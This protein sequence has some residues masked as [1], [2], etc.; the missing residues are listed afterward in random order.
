MQLLPPLLCLVTQDLPHSL[1]QWALWSVDRTME[2]EPRGPL[3]P[4][5]SESGGF[6]PQGPV[7]FSSPALAQSGCDTAL[8]SSG[9]CAT[10]TRWLKAAE[11]Y[12][13]TVL[14]ARSPRSVSGLS[15][16]VRRSCSHWR[17]VRPGPLPASGS[18]HSF[19]CGRIP[20][21]SASEATAPS[22]VHQISASLL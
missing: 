5:P 16:R 10:Q 3:H 7:I 18:R 19:T 14:E 8:A 9:C 17:R 20:P 22:S 15:Q 6:D 4:G 1:I 11:I 13:P 12:S 2:P 21:V